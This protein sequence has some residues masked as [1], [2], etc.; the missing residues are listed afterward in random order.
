MLV[1]PEPSDAERRFDQARV[2]SGSGRLRCST[3]IGVTGEGEFSGASV[4]PCL[5]E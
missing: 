4:R 2:I 5:N 1:D 3:F